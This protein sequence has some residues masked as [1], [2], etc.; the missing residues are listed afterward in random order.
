MRGRGTPSDEEFGRIIRETAPRMFR[1]AAR[2]MGDLDE[3]DDVLQDGYIRAYDAIQAGTFDGRSPVEA[4]LYRVVVNTALD[5]L[6]RGR[7]RRAREDVAAPAD[8]VV[9]ESSLDA[10]AALRELADWMSDLPAGERAALVLK[11]IEGHT[12]AEVGVLLGCSEGAVEQRL[13]RARAFLRERR[14]DA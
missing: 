3:A 11:E 13:V 12:A 8:R 7:R 6:R 10:R 1:V 4:W 14:R 9:S 5:A 2:L